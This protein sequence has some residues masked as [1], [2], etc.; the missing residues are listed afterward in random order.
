MGEIDALFGELLAFYA[1]RGVEVVVVSEYGITDVD[2]PVALNREFRKRGWFTVKDELGL[3]MADLGASR[4]FAIADH[5]VAHVHVNDETLLGE[6]K[7]V[8]EGL[9]GVERVLEGDGKKAAGIDHARS[10]DLVVVADSRSW[11]SYYYWLDDRVAPDFARCVDIH[12]KIGY[13]PV[14]LF[15]DPALCCPK[16]KVAW[17]L[18]KK[19]LGMRMLMDVVPLD[20]SLVKG[21]HGRLPEDEADWPVLA[22]V[23]GG[24]ALEATGVFGELLKLW[25]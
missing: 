1:K 9:D 10:G 17:R 21:S 22:G 11:F 8:L 7:A 15:L 14:E 18:L 3:E 16:L 19:K 13:D 25:E 2:R 23:S 6:V 4:V 20:G 5:Q 12:R 24:P